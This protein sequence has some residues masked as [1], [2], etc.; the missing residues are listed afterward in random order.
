MNTKEIGKK[1]ASIRDKNGISKV[2]VQRESLLTFGQIATIEAGE[3]N[4]TVGSL[5]KYAG[6][7]GAKIEIK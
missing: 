2:K 3:S 1:L 4:Y 6:A 7:V 5:L